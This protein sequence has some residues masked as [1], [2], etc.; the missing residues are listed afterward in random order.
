MGTRIHALEKRLEE[1]G[2]K[3]HFLGARPPNLL[4]IALCGLASSYLRPCPF[5]LHLG[6]HTLAPSI[7]ASCVYM[8]R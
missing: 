3:D 4:I 6:S 7:L 1:R 8:Q 5:C 2:I